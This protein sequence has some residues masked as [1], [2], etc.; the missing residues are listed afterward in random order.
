MLQGRSIIICCIPVLFISPLLTIFI[1]YHDTPIYLTVL[2]IFILLLL[3]GVRRTGS[4]WT[5]WYQKIA[6]M[7]DAAL[8]SWFV[9][10]LSES[11]KED[12]Q[13]LTDPKVL[14]LARQSLQ[15]AVL[16]ER[17]KT[18]FARASQDPL[19]SKLV[20]S[21]Q[22]TIFLMVTVQY[23]QFGLMLTSPGMVLPVHGCSQTHHVQL[24]MERYHQ[25][26]VRLPSKIAARDT[27]PQWF[28]PLATSRRRS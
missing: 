16:A 25:S 27:F 5:T 7:D 12:I 15:R 22:A 24:I 8:R 1:P 9:N 2:Y 10:R 28:H 4:R 18:I 20:D 19:V 13:K 3:L 6:L 17:R 26:R 21:Y 11:E 23:V 14:I